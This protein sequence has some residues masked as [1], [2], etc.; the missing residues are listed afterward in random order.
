MEIESV[1]KCKCKF[2]TVQ[3]VNG[4]SNCMRTATF[5]RTFGKAPKITS[6]FWACNNC[7][8]QWNVEN[9]EQQQIGRAHV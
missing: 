7:S 8:N 1:A 5:K 2:L 4:A 9:G 3:F 6:T